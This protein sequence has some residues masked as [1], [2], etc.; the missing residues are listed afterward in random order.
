MSRK[1]LPRKPVLRQPLFGFFE[2]LRGKLAPA[3][4]SNFLL[5]DKPGFLQHANMLHHR[6]QGHAV[7]LGQFCDGRLAEYQGRQNRAARG[8][9]EG[10]KGGVKF[11][12]ILNHAV[13]YLP[14]PLRYQAKSSA[15]QTRD[16]GALFL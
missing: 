6:G 7:R 5:R 12:R 11:A 10:A 9:S 13:Y 4:A 16:L 1:F 15:R 14:A 3:R 2:R 8:V